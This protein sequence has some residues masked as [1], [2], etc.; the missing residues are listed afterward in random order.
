MKV[1]VRS[2][3]IIRPSSSPTQE[4]RLKNYKLSLVDQTALN[5][6]VPF[7]FFYNSPSSSGPSNNPTID[8]LKKSLSKTLS[9]MYPL[10]GRMKEDKVTIECNDAGVEFIVADVAENLSC[11]LDNP[12]M[13]AFREL[14]PRTASYEPR[15]EGKVLLMIQ[16]NR[17]RCGGMAMAAFVSHAVA[18]GLTVATLFKTWAT[19]NRGC[20]AVN[21]ISGFVSD[22]SR[23]FPPLTDT[24]GIEQLARNAAEESAAQPP[25]KYTVRMFVFT[26][27]AISQLREQL[28]V[29]DTNTGALLRPSR[30]E[31]LTALVWSAV[32]KAASPTVNSHRLSCMV[33]LRSRME[34]PLPPN[35]IGNLV[36]GAT[37]EWEEKEGSATAVQLVQRIRDSL[38]AVNDGVARKMYGEG[39]LLRAALAGGGGEIVRKG[40]SNSKK[41]SSYCLY[42]SSLCGLPFFEADFGW[43]RPIRVV[44]VLKDSAAFMDTINGGIELW[45]GLPKEVMQ[46]LMQN[47]HFLGY[48]SGFP[49]SSL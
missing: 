26:A 8:E 24:S 37:V 20:A 30:T 9:L 40:D 46:A 23:I 36:H 32:I 25:E 1:E 42:T 19:I 15:P 45:M 43:G 3:E 34:P 41:D 17:F 47:H 39:G 18:D 31:A 22:Q 21:G 49:K 13:A 4:S 35:C 48:V 11:L 2:K 38:R 7:V 29:K 28:T 27:N 16:V 10:A 33:N 44:N 6:R 14:I 12:E 5:F